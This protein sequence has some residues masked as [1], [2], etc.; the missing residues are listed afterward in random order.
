MQAV[1]AMAA[2]FRILANQGAGYD[3]AKADFRRQR[4]R[5][6][7][8]H[9][10]LERSWDTLRHYP[11]YARAMQIRAE[12][13]TANYQR[14][15]DNQTTLTALGEA[16]ESLLEQCP[17]AREMSVNLRTYEAMLDEFRVSLYAQHLGTSRP[18]SVKRLKEQW[19]RVE[20][21]QRTSGGRTVEM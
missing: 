21:W 13:I 8:E 9:A 16:S 2:G 10:F 17:R 7:G 5:L 4:D 6:L 3:A 19:Q 15:Q 1:E 18:V 12:R 11:R 14:D 20:A